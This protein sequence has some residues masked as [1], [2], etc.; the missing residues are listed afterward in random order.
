M[1]LLLRYWKA[2]AVVALLGVVY[3]WGWSNG[4]NSA[5]VACQRAR[6]ADAAASKQ[7][8]DELNK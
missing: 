5:Q 2:L 7:L 8:A 6:N 4:H 1:T 3:F